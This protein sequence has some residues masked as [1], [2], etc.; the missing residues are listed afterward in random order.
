[1]T[2]QRIYRKR[3][4]LFRNSDIRNAIA[5]LDPDRDY[6]HIVYLLSC[7]EFPFDVTRSLEIALFHTYGSVPVSR[8]LDAPPGNSGI[9]AR[10]VTTIRG[11]SSRISCR[12]GWTAAPGRTPSGE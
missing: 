7:Y 11:C 3:W 12:M 4:R 5:E 9:K 2:L 8:L 6:E 1:V 10:S